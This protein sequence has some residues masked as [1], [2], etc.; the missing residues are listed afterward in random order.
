MVYTLPPIFFRFVFPVPLHGFFDLI[1]GFL[2]TYIFC[3]LSL[4]FIAGATGLD[5]EAD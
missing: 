4:S 2:Q 3:V 1:V 5:P